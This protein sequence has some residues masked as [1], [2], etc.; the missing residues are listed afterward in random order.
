MPGKMHKTGREASS[1]WVHI[2]TI[3]NDKVTSFGEFN[4]TAQFAEALRG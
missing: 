4:D 3:K 1:D 2:L